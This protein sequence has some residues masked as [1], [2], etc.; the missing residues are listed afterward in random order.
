MNNLSENMISDKPMEKKVQQGDETVTIRPYD[1]EQ[2]EAQVIA[3]WQT[4]FGSEIGPALWRWKYI[5]NPYETAILICENGEGRPVVF[6]GGIP[7]AATFQGKRVV[8]IHLSDIMSHPDYR[9]SG[10]FIHTANAF[11]EAFGTQSA[12]YVMYGFPGKQHFD[13]GCKYLHYQAIQGG[14]AYFMGRIDEMARLQGR[15]SGSF[16]KVEAVDP[17]FDLLW[18]RHERLYP[19]AVIR[20]A[21]FMQWRF[22]AHPLNEYEVWG[23]DGGWLKKQWQGVMV[24][25]ILAEEKKAVIVDMLLPGAGKTVTAFMGQLAKMLVKRGV[26]TVET[27]LPASHFLV[28]LL[29]DAGLKQKKEPTGIIPTIRLFDESMTYDWASENGYYTMADGDLF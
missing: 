10:L 25:R 23:M 22:F 21:A 11:F 18:Q 13:I 6:Y 2:D 1:P 26:E 8:M 7:Y 16:F 3:L 9:G 12:T 4:V 5:D 29:E 19:L 17:R 15:F 28:P 27:W 24:L 20:D 14:A